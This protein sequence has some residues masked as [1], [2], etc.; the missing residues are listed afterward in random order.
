MNITIGNKI[1]KNLNDI[2]VDGLSGTFNEEFIFILKLEDLNEKD[3]YSFNNN[4][5]SF[6]LLK[7]DMFNDIIGDVFSFSICVSE[8]IDNSEIFFDFKS[9]ANSKFSKSE[10]FKG[11][12]ILSDENNI[13][14][15]VRNFNFD[16]NFS[17]LIYNSYLTQNKNSEAS[18][19]NYVPLIFQEIF[20]NEPEENLKLYSIGRTLI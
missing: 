19:I 2:I 15:A 20:K 1:P 14:L 5:I 11:K 9:I 7:L 18:Y 17:L 3:I 16:S 13:V 6:D 10:S 4:L 12:F 8:L